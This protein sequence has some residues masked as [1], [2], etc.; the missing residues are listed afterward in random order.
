VVGR[1]RTCMGMPRGEFRLGEAE[2]NLGEKEW[3]G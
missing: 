2:P 3:W 1:G